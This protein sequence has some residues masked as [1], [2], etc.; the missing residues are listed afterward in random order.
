MTIL[1]L[2]FELAPGEI[3]QQSFQSVADSDTCSMD[4]PNV[5]LR[6]VRSE[7]ECARRCLL[8]STTVIYNFI[9]VEARCEL[10]E[11]KGWNFE[12]KS[13]CKAKQASCPDMD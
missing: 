2:L 12:E 7:L 5:V 9:S 11:Y 1:Q 3:L 4:E 6:Y 10:Y 8:Q 13:G